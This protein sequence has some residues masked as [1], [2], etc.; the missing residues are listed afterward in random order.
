MKKYALALLLLLLIPSL[1]ACGLVEKF[2]ARYRT[3]L[4]VVTTTSQTTRR[5]TQATTTRPTTLA[6]TK[7]Q[8]T[9]PVP[10]EATAAPTQAPTLNSYQV[11]QYNDGSR[12]EGIVVSGQPEG[13]GVMTWVDG[14]RYEGSFVNGLFHGYGIFDWPDGDHYEGSWANG[15]REGMGTYT[16]A[17]GNVFTGLWVGGEPAPTP[18]PATPTPFPFDYNYQ[19]SLLARTNMVI[20]SARNY[21]AQIE[22]EISDLA[23]R[24]AFY[25]SVMD[26]AKARKDAVQT[27]LV[28]LDALFAAISSAATNQELM[29]LEQN[30]M[31]FEAVY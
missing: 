12:Y 20:S 4:P 2:K 19:I 6:P 14:K 17:S 10:T 1:C 25:S 8:V 11:I 24:G 22:A 3:E 23:A 15:V 9:A 30:L 31:S 28:S 18:A 13:Y 26:Q 16:W 5:P 21:L 27:D 7:A 29:G